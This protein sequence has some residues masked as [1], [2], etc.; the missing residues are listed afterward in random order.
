MYKI[1]KKAKKAKKNRTG[2][3]RNFLH[4]PLADIAV[5]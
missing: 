1:Q 4:F 2:K 3:S 5:I